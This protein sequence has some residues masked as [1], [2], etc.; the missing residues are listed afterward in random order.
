[1]LNSSGYS[2]A[3]YG[4]G[5][6]G[7]AR[8][9]AGL[10]LGAVGAGERDLREAATDGLQEALDGHASHLH[11][12]LEDLVRVLAYAVGLDRAGVEDHEVL[13]LLLDLDD[14]ATGKE[15]GGDDSEGAIHDVLLSAYVADG[16]DSHADAMQA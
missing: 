2:P 11:A 5:D 4:R 9:R 10:H 15:A 14:H 6:P 7:L 12:L 3:A 1:M 16:N 13:D 8:V